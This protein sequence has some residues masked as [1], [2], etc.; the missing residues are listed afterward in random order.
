MVV[1]LEGTQTSGKTTLAHAL[2]SHCRER[3]I[4]TAFAEEPARTSPLVEEVLTGVRPAFD[5]ICEVDLFAAQIT[6]QIRASRNHMLLVADK[7]IANVLA[8][9]QHIFK[10]SPTAE[11]QR[12]I[13]AMLT[14]T[15]AWARCYDHVFLCQDLFYQQLETAAYRTPIFG[16]QQPVHETLRGV[17]VESG[18]PVINVPA[19]LS[20]ADRV[21]FIM[22]RLDIAQLASHAHNSTSGEITASQ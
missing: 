2:V 3:G 20:T 17:L 1:A 6:N 12:L 8:Y 21:A 22:Q 18:I 16:Y 14:F 5:L 9:C 10:E 19:G 11:D 7:T 13:Q 15:K 4:H